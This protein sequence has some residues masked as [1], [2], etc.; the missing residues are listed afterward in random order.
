MFPSRR[1]AAAR[2]LLIHL[3]MPTFCSAIAGGGPDVQAAPLQ[4][5]VVHGRVCGAAL[6]PGAPCK[7]LLACAGGRRV[8][9][10]AAML[11]NR[12]APRRPTLLRPALM[13]PPPCISIHYTY[14][15]TYL[16]GLPP[17]IP[18]TPHRWSTAAARDWTTCWRRAAG[19]PGWVLAC[20]AV[21]RAVLALPGVHGLPAMHALSCLTCCACTAVTPGSVSPASRLQRLSGHFRFRQTEPGFASP[22]YGAGCQAAALATPAVHGTRRRQ[23]WAGLGC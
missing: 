16:M 14:E 7:R 12:S 19:T 1:P 10:E 9:A 3:V 20:D 15:C 6:P 17:C 5:C 2:P 4:H 8:P 22:S 18:S 21:S 23:G 13:R 11:R